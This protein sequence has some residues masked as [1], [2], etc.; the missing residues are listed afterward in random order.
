MIGRGKEHGESV[1]LS[2]DQVKAFAR[3]VNA[4]KAKHAG[5]DLR[6]CSYELAISSYRDPSEAPVPEVRS[7]K[8]PTK[9]SPCRDRQGHC[10]A[11]LGQLAIAADGNVYPCPSWVMTDRPPVGNVLEQ[12]LADIWRD[13]ERWKPI[14]GAWMHE[15]IPLCNEC[16][17]FST[18]D[19]GIQCR[20][21]SIQWYD[22][23]FGP[24]PTCLLS[25]KELGLPAASVKKFLLSIRHSVR[26]GFPIEEILSDLQ[27]VETDLRK[28]KKCVHN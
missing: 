25:W 7:L 24:P 15:D 9:P 18:C 27:D 16:P 11:A 17:H 19:Y 20:V 3:R 21:P 23:P 2:F 12:S 4:L 26:S 13:A 10:S 5:W 8:G 14:R 28:Q 22:S 6:F 1:N